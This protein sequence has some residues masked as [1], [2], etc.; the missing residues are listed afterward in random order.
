MKGKW[1]LAGCL[2]TLACGQAPSAPDETVRFDVV[3]VAGRPVA[4]AHL[5][6]DGT[7]V[8]T[9]NIQGVLE[10]RLAGG[11]DP[12]RVELRCPDHH[13]PAESVRSLTLRRTVDLSGRPLVPP[14]RLECEPTR[15]AAAVVV[16]TSP[17]QELPVLVQGE[18]VGSTG[19]DG[20]FHFLTHV[21]R[22]GSLRV[23]LDTSSRPNLRLTTPP[24][25]F[26]VADEDSV[27]VY[28][29]TFA[30]EQKKRS[31]RSA[32]RPRHVPYRLD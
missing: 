24:R 31:A 32:P 27:L 5:K 14:L 29:A 15:V 8:G 20:L 16:R 26:T 6:V 28:D 21:P 18:K 13:A 19:P 10:V 1:S 2:I 12:R 22:H 30:Q 4:G 17:P 23:E 3:T 9:T 7:L 11:N 25:T